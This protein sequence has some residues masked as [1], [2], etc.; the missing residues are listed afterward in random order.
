MMVLLLLPLKQRIN[1]AAIAQ[2][3]LSTATAQTRHSTHTFKAAQQL[4]SAQ[5]GVVR[6]FRLERI[7]ATAEQKPVRGIFLLNLQAPIS[8]SFFIHLLRKAA[9][10]ISAHA[11]AE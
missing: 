9:V 10:H 7:K 6:G 8:I 11:A 4:F 5:P 3:Q 2:Q 1:S